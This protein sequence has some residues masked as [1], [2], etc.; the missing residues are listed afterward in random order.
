MTVQRPLFD[1]G[2]AEPLAAP[3]PAPVQATEG[4]RT[5]VGTVADEKKRT[6]THADRIL[7]L[8][9]EGTV[10]NGELATITP[11]YGARILDL[12]KAGHEIETVF[13]NKKSGLVIYRLKEGT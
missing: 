8:L 6:A 1:F 2:I 12:R 9:R 11:R 4:E 7:A 13:E 5:V 3:A 10:T